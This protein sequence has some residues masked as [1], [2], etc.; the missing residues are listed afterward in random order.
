MVSMFIFSPITRVLDVFTQKDLN[1]CQ[2]M[3]LELLKDYDKSV[4]Y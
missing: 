1:L 4:L 2:I 3:W